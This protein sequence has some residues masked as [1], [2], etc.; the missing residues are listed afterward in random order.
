MENL[1][2]SIFE[3]CNKNAAHQIHHYSS[4]EVLSEARCDGRDAAALSI[5]NAKKTKK[6]EKVRKRDTAKMT[7]NAKKTNKL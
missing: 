3:C 4:V 7:E 2:R 5:E 6:M 1:C